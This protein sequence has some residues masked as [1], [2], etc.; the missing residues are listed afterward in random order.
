L[1]GLGT[2]F[3]E[4]TGTGLFGETSMFNKFV[5][6]QNL[7]WPP[8]TLRIGNKTCV[9]SLNQPDRHTKR[10]HY[11]GHFPFAELEYKTDLPLKI[12]LKAF[13]PFV[14]GDSKASN[15]PAVS[16]G[17]SLKNLSKRTIKGDLSFSFPL[18]KGEISRKK[19][20]VDIDGWR[21]ILIREDNNGAFSIATKGNNIITK[22]GKQKVSLSVPLVLEPGKTKGITFILTWF[23]PYFKDSGHE[24]HIHAY[25]RSFKDIEVLLSYFIKNK[26]NLER[27]TLDWQRVIFNKNRWPDW[28]P[29]ALV[30][31][32]YSYARNTL[33]VI[34]ERPDNWYDKVGL[35][36]HSES[37]TGCP[38]TETIVCRMHGHFPTLFF[39]PEL[40]RSTLNAF[41]HFQLKD[42][43]IPFSFGQPCSLRDP[44]Y[45]CQHP[46]NGAQYVQM[47]Y[48]YYLRTSDKK[49]L[50][51]YF[52]SV[53]K[54]IH[55]QQKI[56]DYDQ[57]GLVNDHPHA[58]PGDLW[59]ANQFYDCWPWYGT[60][61]YVAGTGLAALCCAIEIANTLKKKKFRRECQSWLR[62]GIASYHK[63]L[64]TGNYY[65]LYN[66]PEKGLI[67]D[68]C[69]ANQLMG[70]WC[71]GILGIKGFLPPK[72]VR[73][74]LETI[75]KLN[76][77][78][79]KIGFINGMCPDGTPE[80][81][82]KDEN[83]HAEQVFV[84]ENSCAAMTF[85]LYDGYKD[86]G[87]KALEE[88]Y[89][90][91]I[92]T[93]RTPW[94]QH[95]LISSKDGHPIWGRDYYSNMVIWV[96]PL[97]L[98]GQDLKKFTSKRAMI[99]KGMI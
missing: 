6:P 98:S 90:A 33:W 49:F 37:F 24:P 7:N 13:T 79:T 54:A 45:H 8:F 5:R 76:F 31:S 60:S 67:S 38:I 53:Q 55:Y 41:K 17:F 91:I 88:I 25:Y 66:D 89:K 34:S 1:G 18:R 9:L 81:I 47:V 94:R 92:E 93:H 70:E 44:R 12:F 39:F 59:P 58:L 65:R 72:N 71:T 84:G 15:I 96:L 95:C 28:I 64:W 85:M 50:S 68:V 73:L 56:L 23:Y 10:I 42:G 48:R 43:E 16:F 78:A 27:R 86:I 35:F 61:A 19:E 75:K 36:T 87:L 2:G 52:S 3:I 82:G 51:E 21:G 11:W 57:D 32:L 74:A 20:L 83:N 80:K 69:L 22:R 62:R 40:E 46:L 4:L 97:I 29:N 26:E 30:K 77:R 14:L 99:S 63:K